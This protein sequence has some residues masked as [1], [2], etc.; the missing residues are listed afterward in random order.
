MKKELKEVRSKRKDKYEVGDRFIHKHYGTIYEVV[1]VNPGIANKR[2][3]PK[4]TVYRMKPTPNEFYVIVNGKRISASRGS[5]DITH[6]H[7]DRMI[8]FDRWRILE[9]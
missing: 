9:Q 4:D 7:I 1:D 6:Y 3:K 5:F 8:T 2:A